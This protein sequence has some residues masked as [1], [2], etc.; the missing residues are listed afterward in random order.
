MQYPITIRTVPFSLRVGN[1]LL[2]DLRFVTP[3][4]PAFVACITEY[5]H[6]S[7]WTVATETMLTKS[8]L[9]ATTVDSPLDLRVRLNGCR[10]I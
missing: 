3:L 5:N 1:C 4:M 6:V 2:R 7:G 10:R 9:L 8:K